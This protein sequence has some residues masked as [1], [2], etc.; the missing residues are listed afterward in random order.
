MRHL[1]LFILAFLLSV[2]TFSQNLQVFSKGKN[3]K[4]K[5]GLK[6][7]AGNEVLPAQFRLIWNFDGFF[8]YTDVF[9]GVINPAGKVITPP[10][11][12]HIEELYYSS[13]FKARKPGSNLWALMDSSG[14]ELTPFK[15]TSIDLHWANRGSEHGFFKV[16][17]GF[18]YGFVNSRGQE[19]IDANK[20]SSAS[21]IS[22]GEKLLF[23]VLAPKPGGDRN[24]K[25]TALFDTTGKIVSD[26]KYQSIDAFER[27]SVTYVKCADGSWGI[28]NKELTEIVPCGK[29]KNVHLQYF[30]QRIIVSENGK[31]GLLDIAGKIKVPLQYDSTGQY[32]TSGVLAVKKEGKW[33]MMD[34]DGKIVI[35]IV[36]D[37]VD[38]Y[39]EDVVRLRKGTEWKTTTPYGEELS[40]AANTNSALAE[41]RELEKALVEE[42]RRFIAGQLKIR[43]TKYVTEM[44]LSKRFLDQINEM[45]P[46]MKEKTTRI[47]DV[48]LQFREKE[49]RLTT[50]DI[51]KLD[52]SIT[53]FQKYDDI[54]RTMKPGDYN[55]F[56]FEDIEMSDV[57][58]NTL[59]KI[60]E[61]ISQKNAPEK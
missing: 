15:Y 59:K 60:D 58:N 24:V 26:Y 32:F 36:Y 9:Q 5:F 7:E 16:N 38:H 44:E 11:Y 8:I 1:V 50:E 61:K 22:I 31:F 55:K 2:T 51:Q 46:S 4:E 21:R 43:E 3:K 52:K 27:R 39:R 14:R 12:S 30:D 42:I 40:G 34:R 33:G 48:L 17:I 29:Y 23:E 47:L 57:W 13:F 35:P 6:D 37:E 19:V 49:S 25:F 41:V 54:I 10:I 53:A 45:R 56:I 18:N 20:Y 28:I